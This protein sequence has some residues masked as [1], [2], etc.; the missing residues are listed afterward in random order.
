MEPSWVTEHHFVHWNKSDDDD[1]SDDGLPPPAAAKPR[2]TLACRRAVRI[3][4]KVEAP[5]SKPLRLKPASGA[6]VKP[7]CAPASASPVHPVNLITLTGAELQTQIKTARGSI[8]MANI[9]L[10]RYQKLQCGYMKRLVDVGLD[11]AVDYEFIDL[12]D[13]A[14]DQLQSVK[15]EDVYAQAAFADCTVLTEI[16]TCRA[17]LKDAIHSCRVNIASMTEALAVADEKVAQQEHDAAGPAYKIA[18]ACSEESL[19]DVSAALVMRMEG[20]MPSDAMWRD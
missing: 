14:L 5:S 7:S 8:D 13:E 20:A 18:C 1:S 10:S 19:C 11:D 6:I 3:H 2:V 17:S 9:F 16:T 12:F 15:I 4:R